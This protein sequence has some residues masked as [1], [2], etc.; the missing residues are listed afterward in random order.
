MTVRLWPRAC[1]GRT[2]VYSGVARVGSD[3]E[4]LRLELT[5]ARRVPGFNGISGPRVR[6]PIVE[7]FALRSIAEIALDEDA[8]GLCE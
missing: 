1:P 8:G 7:V 6:V 5:A 2:L 4:M 3:G